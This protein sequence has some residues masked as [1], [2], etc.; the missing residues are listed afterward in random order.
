MEVPLVDQGYPVEV[1]VV[2][3]SILEGELQGCLGSLV[4]VDLVGEVDPVLGLV[5]GPVAA[6]G[7]SLAAAVAVGAF[8]GGETV[9]VAETPASAASTL[10]VPVRTVVV[11]EPVDSN[12]TTSSPEADCSMWT[13]VVGVSSVGVDSSFG[14]VLEVLVVLVAVVEEEVVA[15]VRPSGV[16][17]VVQESF[18]EVEGYQGPGWGVHWNSTTLAWPEPASGILL[19]LSS[20][21][22]LPPS[23]DAFLDAFDGDTVASVV[24][25]DEG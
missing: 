14:E 24:A 5:V 10:A 12:S 6:V 4:G 8:V 17:A 25:A 2:R 23:S 16:L 11:A 15:G 3:G 13:P 1:P 20:V 21:H 18:V 7:A 19:L 9:V 22:T